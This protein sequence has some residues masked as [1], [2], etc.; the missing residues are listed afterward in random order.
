MSVEQKSIDPTP[1]G[2]ITT[3]IVLL[4][5][6]PILF[7]VADTT[8]MIAVLPWSA[9]AFPLV[10]LTSVIAFRHGHVLGAVANGVMSELTLC[11]N[12]VWAIVLIAYQML[13]KGRSRSRHG[14]EGICGRCSIF[15]RSLY[16]ALHRDDILQIKEYN[17]GTFY[18]HNF[19]RFL[20][21]GSQRSGTA[22]AKTA[23]RCL[24]HQ[25]CVVDDLFRLRDAGTRHTRAENT[26]LLNPHTK[27]SY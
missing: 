11:Q 14:C 23:C 19:S 6:W 25:L 21:H 22:S 17:D 8:A 10:L 27:E 1:L 18:V 7:G 15:G 16:A 24:Y 4:T 20:L 5:L 3:G 9:M 2:N 12:A 13:R 26:P